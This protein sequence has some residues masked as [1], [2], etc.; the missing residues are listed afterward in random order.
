MSAIPA[1]CGLCHDP[2]TSTSLTKESMGVHPAK[3]IDHFFHLSCLF[4]YIRLAESL[5]CPVC[6]KKISEESIADVIAGRAFLDAKKNC[7][8][9]YWPP[10]REN[11]GNLYKKYYSEYSRG[12][13]PPPGPWTAEEEEQSCQELPIARFAESH[14]PMLSMN[15][16]K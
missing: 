6:H 14:L 15:Q 9:P 1:S 10:L 3:K 8:T 11:E 13:S 7:D 4:D 16:K 5:D 12:V 2:L